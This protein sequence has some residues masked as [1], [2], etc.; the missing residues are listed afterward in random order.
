VPPE[1]EP[2]LGQRRLPRELKFGVATAGFQ[3]EGGYNGP[4]EPANNWSR[5]EAEGRVE[6]SG[7]ALDFWNRY[8]DHLDRVAALGCDSFRMSIEWARIEPDEGRIDQPAVQRY[9][10]ILQACRDRGLDPLVT[11]LHF[12]NPAWMGE[13]LWLRPDSPERF[14]GWAARAIDNFGDMCTN[15]V[16][17]NEINILA[18]ETYV[19]GTF[20]PARRGDLRSFLRA[21]DNLL[22]AHVAAYERIHREQPG[23]TVAT[24]NYSFSAYELDRLGIDLLLS[25]MHSVERSELTQWLEARRDAFLAHIP[26]A[27]G[28]LTAFAERSIRRRLAR[29]V[30]LDRAL[31]RTASAVQSS[32]SQ[33]LLDVVQIDFYDPVVAHHLR[34]PGHRTAGGRNW[35]P[36]RMLWDDPPSPANLAAYC[37]ASQEDGLDLWVVENGLCNRLRRG[38][39]Y[40]RLDGWSRTEYLRR[41]LGALA[42]A[43]SVGVPITGYW[44]WT[45]ADNYEWGSYEPRFGI[46][47]VDRERGLRWSDKDSM[48]EDAAGTYR[49]LVS[50]M[51]PR[52]DAS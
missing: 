24:N 50:T 21:T 3:I 35:G 44:H 2:A 31:P 39:S 46:F 10:Q 41:N 8:E 52:G 9:R 42:G 43:A 32:D 18:L 51:R 22:A 37:A 28:S 45:L 40:R 30:P 1:S 7:I 33:R 38:R 48:G 16:T 26:A 27:E 20:P 11:L 49:D 23:A 13:E 15:W 5:W 25:R 19:T 29:W 34:A 4:G 12:T 6:P 14:A 17:I 36:A 47:G